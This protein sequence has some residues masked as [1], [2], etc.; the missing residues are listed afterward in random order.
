MKIS[1]DTMLTTPWRTSS[2]CDTGGQCV[3]VAQAG[4]TWLVR[5]SADPACRYLAFSSQAWQAFTD[6]VKDTT[7]DAED[8][9]R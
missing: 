6:S 8:T 4:A 1:Q 2:Y 5:D 3:Q 7:T 9:A